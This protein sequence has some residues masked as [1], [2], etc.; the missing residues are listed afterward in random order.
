MIFK[1]CKKKSDA[2]VAKNLKKNRRYFT[3]EGWPIIKELL[4]TKCSNCISQKF[5]TS[6]FEMQESS[7]E[8]VIQKL[9][10]ATALCYHT[11]GIYEVS[12]VFEKYS[13]NY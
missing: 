9:Q 12:T 8:K 5:M 10:L 7:K 6:S 2:L 3:K 1:H 11:S 4:R 13:K